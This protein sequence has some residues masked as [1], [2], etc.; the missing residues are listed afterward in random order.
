M[1]E[2]ADRLPGEWANVDD[3]FER[4][5]EARLVETSTLA[6]RVAGDS[7]YPITQLSNYPIHLSSTFQGLGM[8]SCSNSRTA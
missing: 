5:F 6:F 4:E 3:E 2:Y 8:K 7:N 1:N